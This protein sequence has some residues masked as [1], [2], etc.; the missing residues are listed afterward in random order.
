MKSGVLDSQAQVKNPSASI[1][2]P[3][4]PKPPIQDPRSNGPKPKRPYK[5]TPARTAA[6]RANLEKA[7]AAPK[8]KIY[9]P[10]PKRK[11]ANLANLPKAW[12]KRRQEVEQ[13]VDQLDLAF[14]PLGEQVEAPSP[15]PQSEEPCPSP[16]GTAP[17]SQRADAASQADPKSNPAEPEDDDPIVPESDGVRRKKFW[18]IGWPHGRPGVNRQAADYGALE[19]AARALLHRRRALLH[20][21]RREGRQVMRLLTQAA[22]RTVAPTL[23]DILA[24]AC[25]LMTV[26]VHSRPLGRGKRLNER[27]TNILEAFVEKRYGKTGPVVSWMAVLEWMR[28]NA[29]GSRPPRPQRQPRARPKPEAPPAAAEPTARKKRPRPDPTAAAL[30]LPQTLEQFQGLVRRAFCAPSAEPEDEAVRAMLDDLAHSL[31]T[32]LHLF[33]AGLEYE[34][35]ELDEAL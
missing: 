35:Q 1:D 27:V 16:P 7:R 22:E 4:S 20:E 30:D 24:L 32:R 26:L 21:V 19:K 14:P 9:W 33:E 31:W 6:S 13:V 8:E 15:S 11:A 23:R 2:N 5:K 18:V 12:A 29:P 28:G 34:R 17:D 3:A 25:G 10:S